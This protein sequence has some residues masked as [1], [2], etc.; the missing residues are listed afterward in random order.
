MTLSRLF[1]FN[2]MFPYPILSFDPGTRGGAFF[3][4]APNLR[5]GWFFRPSLKT[6]GRIDREWLA[7]IVLGY[8]DECPELRVVVEDVWAMPK[9]GASSSAK[10]I[11]AFAV[12]VGTCLGAGIDPVL[13]RPRRWKKDLGLGKEKNSSV[14]LAL[15][16]YPW[17]E[18]G[19]RTYSEKTGKQLKNYNHDYAEALLLAHW[20]VHY[21]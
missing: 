14:D 20:G 8:R 9:Q 17:C 5:H 10:F 15:A 11:E 13:V 12:F 7:D 1:S 4:Y 16:L 18:T 21:A 3:S 19:L 6:G 2:N